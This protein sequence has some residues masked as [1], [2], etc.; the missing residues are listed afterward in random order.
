[1]MMIQPAP[2][3]YFTAIRDR[4]D[5]VFMGEIANVRNMEGKGTMIVVKL[6]DSPKYATV[7]LDECFNYA[8]SDFPLPALPSR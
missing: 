3:M 7:Y 4:D 8:W 2:G 1:M 5:K 6:A